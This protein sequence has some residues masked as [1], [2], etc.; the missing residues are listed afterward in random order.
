[1]PRLKMYSEWFDAVMCGSVITTMVLVNMPVRWHSYYFTGHTVRIVVKTV[2]IE[3]LYN[4]EVQ[5]TL[6]MT[7]TTML[8][9]RSPEH[10]C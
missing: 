7:V 6:L 5:N 10:T 8:H 4:F 2:K 3:S 9:I 1:M